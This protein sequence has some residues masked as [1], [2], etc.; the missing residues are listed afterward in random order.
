MKAAGNVNVTIA[1]IN[2]RTH[3]TIW[4]RIASDGD[5]AADRIIQFVRATTASRA[6]TR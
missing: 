3:S 1:M 2:G 4:G 6:S 5:E